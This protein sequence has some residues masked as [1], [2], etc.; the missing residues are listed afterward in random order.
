GIPRQGYDLVDAE[1]SKIGVVTSGT[2]S[3]SLNQGIGMGYL[4][5]EFT[6]PGSEIY[7]DIRGRKLKAEVV[8]LPFYQG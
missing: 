3:P 8:K 7:V 4:K 2:Q 6:Q 5:K 1:G